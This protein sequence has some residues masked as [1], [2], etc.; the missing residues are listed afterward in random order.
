MKK[1]GGD[2]DLVTS[3]DTSVEEVAAICAGMRDPMGGLLAFV[4]SNDAHS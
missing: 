3:L 2:K 4:I 1:T